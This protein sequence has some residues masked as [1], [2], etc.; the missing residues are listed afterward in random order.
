MAD[1]WLHHKGGSLIR[2]SA[3]EP[4]EFK[5]KDGAVGVITKVLRILETIQG[6]PSGLTL[7]PICDVTGIN[8]ST[9]HRFLKHLLREEY[10]MRTAAGAYMIGPKLSRMTTR[11]NQWDTLLA[12]AR[13]ILWELWK[14][15]AETVNLASLD[16]ETVLY[17]EVFESPHEFRLSSKVG[18]RRP[19][20][21]TALGKALA[22]FLP[23]AQQERLLS[24]MKLEMATP[25]SIVSLAKFRHELEKVRQQGYAV[26]NEEAVL[27]ARCLAA[28]V[29][30][31]DRNPVA[32][33]SL[34]GPVTRITVGSIPRLT[35]TLIASA[36]SISAAMGCS[37]QELNHAG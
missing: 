7:K 23:S 32:A 1:Y 31:P 21:V 6:S 2:S 16:Q 20:H 8:K 15:T 9:A 3:S 18:T 28:P 27:G 26:D 10:L 13:P 29:F 34:S 30:A 22:A 25:N 12:V 33:V 17:I 5:S 4:Q 35:E 14:S 11:A 36:R 37:V 19:L 24:G